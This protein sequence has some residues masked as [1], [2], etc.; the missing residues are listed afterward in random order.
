MKIAHVAAKLI[1]L[2]KIDNTMHLTKRCWLRATGRRF[3]VN[4]KKITIACKSSGANWRLNEQLFFR[5]NQLKVVTHV[6]DYKPIL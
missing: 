2:H 4:Q 5:P 6:M 3:L 1:S